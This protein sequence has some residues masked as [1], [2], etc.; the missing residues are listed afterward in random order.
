MPFDLAFLKAVHFKPSQTRWLSTR[1]VDCS[2][3]PYG[4]RRVDGGE[5]ANSDGRQHGRPG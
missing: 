1:H 3:S 5:E 2:P 4:N